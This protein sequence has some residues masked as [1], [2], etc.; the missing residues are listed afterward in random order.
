MKM[1]HIL[2]TSK[3]F[4]SYLMHNI[5]GAFFKT[6]FLTLEFPASI[7]DEY[8]IGDNIFKIEEIKDSRESKLDYGV[9]KPVMWQRVIGKLYMVILKKNGEI[10]EVLVS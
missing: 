10:K 4:P 2:S 6:D 3:G 5:K 7:G 1:R 9:S 8:V